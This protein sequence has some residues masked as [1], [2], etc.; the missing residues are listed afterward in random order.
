MANCWSPGAFFIAVLA[1]FDQSLGLA[2]SRSIDQYNY[3]FLRSGSKKSLVIGGDYY[4]Y[5]SNFHRCKC[6]SFQPVV[7]PFLFAWVLTVA[8]FEWAIL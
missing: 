7:C 6:P 8:F 3:L 1:G 4:C 5:G 2:Q